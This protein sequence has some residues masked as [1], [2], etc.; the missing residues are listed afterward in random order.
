MLSHH[1][2][3][4]NNAQLAQG[5]M[6]GGGEME[7]LPVST[8]EPEGL[9]SLRMSRGVELAPNNTFTLCKSCGLLWLQLS[10]E[11]LKEI[12]HFIQQNRKDER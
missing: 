9:K 7:N 10:P 8:F 11:K 4:C 3:Q 1:C 6:T 2:P 5:K 12:N